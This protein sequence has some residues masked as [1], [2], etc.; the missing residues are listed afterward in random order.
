MRSGM[1]HTV[2]LATHLVS[3]PI[4]LTTYCCNFTGMS[5]HNYSCRQI[6]IDQ[7]DKNCSDECTLTKQKF[8]IS[9]NIITQRTDT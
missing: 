8:H 7:N 6:Y 1:S 5:I 4:N 2:V 9:H 3:D